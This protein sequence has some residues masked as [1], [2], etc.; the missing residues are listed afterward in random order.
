MEVDARVTKSTESSFFVILANIGLVVESGGGSDEGGCGP[1]RNLERG[2]LDWRDG[3]DWFMVVAA[4]FVLLSDCF[5]A[6]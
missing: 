5:S 4:E 3:R 1:A 2:T 6:G